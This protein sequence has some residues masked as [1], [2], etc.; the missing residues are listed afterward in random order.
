L[1]LVVAVILAYQQTWHA[2]FIW[3]DDA[4]LTE[5][6][7]IVGELGIKGI[8][9]TSAATYYP[10]VLTSFWVLH[11]LWGLNPLPFHVVN[12]LM[13]AAC[14]LLLWRVLRG[15]NVRGAWLGAALW[16]LHPVMVESVAWIT[17][18]KNTQS[19]FFYLLAI[20]FFIKWCKTRNLADG[21]TAG[22]RYALVLLCAVLAILSKSSTV[23][24]PVVLGLCWWW[25]D[26]RWRWRNVAW[27]SPFFA[28]SLA[29]SA[30]TIWEQKYHSGALGPE[31]N[32][33][34][35]ERVVIAGKVIWFYL[36][37][38]CWPHPLTFIYPRWQIEALNP[39]AYLPVLA[40]A[41]GL[42]FL[43]LKRNGHQ[44]SLFFATAYFV[45]ALFP[46]LGFFSVYFFRY[47][48]V[49]DH[50][51]Y[52]AS[53][54]P[55]ALAGAG[56][57]KVLSCFQK[58]ATFLRPV[59]CGILLSVLGLLTYLQCTQ[60]TDA[61]MLYRTTLS[62]NPSCWLV[63]NNLGMTLAVHG[64]VDEAIAY[65]Q[66]SLAINPENTEAHYNLGIALADR[67]Q[68]DDAIAHYRKALE[69]K[70]DY[71]EAH[72]N[73]GAVLAIRGQFDEAIAHF[74]KALAIKP[75][76]ELAH[77]NF[78]LVLAGLGRVDE[79]IA[80]FQKALELATQQNKQALAESIRAGIRLYE[81]GTPFH[82]LQQSSPDKTLIR[83]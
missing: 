38:L 51:Q 55:I 58:R 28:V 23:V 46:V 40:A 48:L 2:G 14:A 54:G 43:W 76:F 75:D 73:L 24:L 15:L 21:R 4:H 18:L 67:G 78:G 3:D 70:P 16:S 29:A 57:D 60:Y 81:A 71:A 66:K 65:F 69:I 20:L 8:W 45:T 19:C 13:H 31:W 5:N 63:H 77:Y 79:A 53:I 44:R 30:W 35:P 62:R 50:L 41:G 36:G 25:L 72:S 74:Q 37:K 83:R 10:L 39:M 80:H 64:R 22:G 26:R 68:F 34:L 59:V 17:E 27:L 49:G 56:I 33:S 42:L 61:E 12:V 32:Q 52:L 82:K 1:F 47:S 6:P 7:C 9:T 11:A